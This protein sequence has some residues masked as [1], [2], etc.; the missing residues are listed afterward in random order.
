MSTQRHSFTISNAP[1]LANWMVN[2]S[3]WV[4]WLGKKYPEASTLAQKA[5]ALADD[6]GDL[7][8]A[9][10]AEILGD[11]TISDVDDPEAALISL[12]PLSDESLR[13]LSCEVDA[14]SDK[15][16]RGA[17]WDHAQSSAATSDISF[18][19]TKHSRERCV[20]RGVGRR[21]V[22]AALKHGT[23]RPSSNQ[24]SW[25][26]EHHG[27]IVA[28]SGES[29]RKVHTVMRKEGRLLGPGHCW[30]AVPGPS[31][32]CSRCNGARHPGCCRCTARATGTDVMARTWGV[33]CYLCAQCISEQVR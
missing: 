30:P 33:A 9:E 31:A 4:D 32:R 12:L 5:R 6:S 1:W 2:N 21:E 3:E 13:N 22:Q 25:R 17:T 28:G 10:V 7:L 27:V 16:S 23:R 11:M 24:G 8:Y 19:S 18:E 15:S 14:V 29:P 26:V 20:Q